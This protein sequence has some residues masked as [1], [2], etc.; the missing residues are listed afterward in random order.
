MGETSTLAQAPVVNGATPRAV[1]VDD[2]RGVRFLVG[3]VLRAAGYIVEEADTGAGAL[4]L[5]Q[6]APALFVVDVHLPDVS[7]LAVCRA[8]CAA[9]PECAVVVLTAND[10]PRTVTSSLSTG[11]DDCLHKPVIAEILVARAHR[12]VAHAAQRRALR[13]AQ[14]TL[15]DLEHLLPALHTSAA[16]PVRELL[17]RPRA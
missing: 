4:R 14:R 15:A 12:A 16:V 6:T 7:G 8:I 1:I 13:V 10:D 17:H 3:H 11:A 9:Q 5:A 2:D